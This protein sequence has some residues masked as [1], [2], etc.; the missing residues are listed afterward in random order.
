M[1]TC[2]FICPFCGKEKL[3]KFK[4][5]HLYNCPAFDEIKALNELERKGK[6]EEWEIAG[7]GG[8]YIK[9][10]RKYLLN[11]Y[12]VKTLYIENIRLR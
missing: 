9:N 6:I 7:V 4:K 5:E 11:P 12:K 1:K 2:T 8:W 10:G 3:R